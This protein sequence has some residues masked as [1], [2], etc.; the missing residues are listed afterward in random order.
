MRK[1]KN[2]GTENQNSQFPFDAVQFQTRSC[3]GRIAEAS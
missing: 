2:F 3:S 1:D